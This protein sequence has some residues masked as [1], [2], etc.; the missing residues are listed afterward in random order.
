[1]C[2][3]PAQHEV[4]E[5]ADG[6]L[7]HHDHRLAY[8][9]R[10]PPAAEDDGAELLR[11][12]QVLFGY[13]ARQLEQEVRLDELVAGE[14]A[15]VPDVRRGEHEVA[16]SEVRAAAVHNLAQALVAGVAVRQRELVDVP[17]HVDDVQVAAAD[18]RE[19]RT[20]QH[21]ARLRVGY[22]HEVAADALK[23]GSQS[24][25]HGRHWAGAPGAGCGVSAFSMRAP[26][27]VK[28]GGRVGRAFRRPPG[29]G[30]GHV[31]GEGLKPGRANR[32]A[33]TPRRP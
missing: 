21:L 24:G 30:E 23:V 11:H 5:Q 8:Q 31:R 9:R 33:Y 17:A 15:G 3:Q 4:V 16:G 1:M 22:G 26:R 18:G 14:R 29:E 19:A 7:A 13:V 28:L 10:Q 20:D 25:G 27:A 32:E 12:E 6:P 2:A